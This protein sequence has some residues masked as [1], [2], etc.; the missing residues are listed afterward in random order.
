MLGL[1]A[2][3][4]LPTP[5]Q[6]ISGCLMLLNGLIVSVLSLFLSQSAD[7]DDEVDIAAYGFLGGAIIYVI[8]LRALA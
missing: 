5:R 4:M 7:P 8:A 2:G 1:E 3:E 6:A